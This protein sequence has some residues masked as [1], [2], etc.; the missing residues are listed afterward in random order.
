MKQ[1]ERK[2]NVFKDLFWFAKTDLS[3]NFF[4]LDEIKQ[5]RDKEGSMVASSLSRGCNNGTLYVRVHNHA[6]NL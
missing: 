4:I 5:E 1:G 6:C 3:Y 2:C